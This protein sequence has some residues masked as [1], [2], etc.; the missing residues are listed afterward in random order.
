MGSVSIGW[1]V[2]P[3][4]GGA[5]SGRRGVA[6]FAAQCAGL[7]RGQ[8]ADARCYMLWRLR[9]CFLCSGETVCPCSAGIVDSGCGGLD[10]TTRRRAEYPSSSPPFSG[11]TGSTM[12]PVWDLAASVT[13]GILCE[14]LP[15]SFPKSGQFGRKQA[16]NAVAF[17]RRVFRPSGMLNPSWMLRS[18]LQNLR[19]R[20]CRTLLP[21]TIGCVDRSGK[22]PASVMTHRIP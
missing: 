8:R 1:W 16:S 11:F 3:L 10:L 14:E 4:N 9:R 22:P 12:S 17:W 6:A 5:G 15:A 20:F 7:E 2:R 21:P 18:S 13:G 19:R